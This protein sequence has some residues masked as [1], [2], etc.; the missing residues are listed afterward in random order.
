MNLK[1]QIFRGSFWIF[2]GNAGQQAFSLFLF[3]YLA[4]VLNPVDFGI[5]ALAAVVLDFVIA[6][7]RCGQIEVL[8]RRTQS[9][10]II[11]STSF[12][13]LQ[14]LGVLLSVCILLSAR[15]LALAASTPLLESTLYLLAP[16]PFIQN[17][18]AVHEARLRRNFKYRALAM[19]NVLA[20]MSGGIVALWL[21]HRG[22]GIEALIAQRLVY[23]AV[24]TVAVWI[25]VGWKPSFRFDTAAAP[26]LLRSGKDIALATLIGM[27]NPRIVDAMVG[28]MLGA[29]WLGYLKL[30]WR[31]A[32]FVT[33]FA[34]QP[35]TSVA[36]STFSRF[37]HDTAGLKRA[38]LRM[39]QIMALVVLPIFA[40]LALI[41]PVFIPLT[42]GA[43]W[44][45]SII[46]LQLLGVM[47]FA[48]PITYFF[49]PALNAVGATS[50]VLRQGMGQL[51]LTLVLTAIGAQWGVVPVMVAHVLRAYIVSGYN[52]AALK[53]HVGFSLQELSARML[54]IG[55]AIAGMA[56]VVSALKALSLP[57]WAF[58]AVATVC[59]SAA[60][61]GIFFA[62][63]FLRLWPGYTGQ[64]RAVFAEA[65]GKPDWKPR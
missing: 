19:R 63:D 57:P 21:A 18:G 56:V 59:G 58:I 14:A 48:A 3:V 28:F 13:L 8:Q 60:Y 45:D 10:N 23:A 6:G 42:F 41:A 2:V 43:K 27:A 15:P 30:A 51:V 62:G 25:S 37:Q 35:I 16:L 12:W 7:G 54:P 29:H 49:A 38:Y 1:Q 34:V 31:A 47:Y 11:D 55:A 5:V 24:T 46:L 17:V 52:L 61:V 20:T 33:Q 26:T 50:T 65:V 53:R 40:G 9:D 36:L 39:T 22:R 32:D 44:H 4:R 64:L